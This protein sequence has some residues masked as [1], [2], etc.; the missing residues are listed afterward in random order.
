MSVD[1]ERLADAREVL[2]GEDRQRSQNAVYAVYVAVIVAGA[3]GV[4]AA[5]AMLRF[6]DPPW[7]ATH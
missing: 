3:Y 4:P 5:Q 2:A 1:S 6:V 7:L